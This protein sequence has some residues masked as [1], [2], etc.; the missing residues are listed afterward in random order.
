M[1][2]K[3]TSVLEYMDFINEINSDPDFSDPM[4]GTGEQMRSNL[5]DAPDKPADHIWG[6][7]ENGEMTGLFVFLVLEEENYLEM[8]VGLSRSREAYAEMLSYLKENYKGYQVDFVYNPGNTLLSGL[9]REEKA[10]LDAEQQKMVLEREIR[11]ESW[12]QIELYSPKY[13]KS[14]FRC[15]RMRDTGRRIR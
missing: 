15:T 2:K 8:L 12:H 1:L 14:I 10:E 5:L 3:L 13:R 7:Y 11:H 9:L 4:L 6:I